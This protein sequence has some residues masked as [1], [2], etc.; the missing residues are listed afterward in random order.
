MTCI[1]GG[2]AKKKKGS[3]TSVRTLD[4]KKV[5]ILRSSREEAKLVPLRLELVR[6]TVGAAMTRALSN[7]DD[8]KRNR[9]FPIES[10]C[11]LSTGA[12]RLR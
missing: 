8:K 11:I 12:W 1:K 6:A 9:N 5:S 10:T 7:E 4:D 2:E 3:P